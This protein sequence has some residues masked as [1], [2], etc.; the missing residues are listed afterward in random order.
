[1]STV[2][3]GLLLAAGLFVGM[4]VLLDVG[5][6]I[7]NC[8]LAKD[9]EGARA[10]VGALDSV[11][12]ALLGLLIAFTFSG[13]A[14]RF[15]TRRLQ[16]VDEANAIGTAYL[17]LDL[18]PSDAQPPLRERFRRYVHAR[19]EVYRHMP[20]LDA[21][22]HALAE[23]TALQAE[24]WKL[25]VAGCRT[26]TPPCATLLLA[27]LN[28]MIDITTTRAVA[29][30]IHPPWMVFA[31][32]LVL[33]LVASLLAGYGMAGARTR[34]WTH[35]VAFALIMSISLYLILDLE[36]P[37]IGLIRLDPYDDVLAQVLESMK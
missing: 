8:H 7:G 36:F 3:V 9:P 21:A 12:F 13:A 11:V 5:R 28:E 20:D 35:A 27:A 19:L 15:D 17:R 2:L 32:L 33:A 16:I 6:R 14:A 34:S 24:I 30:R 10:G 1:M 22:R 25:S 4:V 18:L 29:A 37:R 31:L 26:E 23:G